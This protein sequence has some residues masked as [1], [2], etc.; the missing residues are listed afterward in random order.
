MFTISLVKNFKSEPLANPANCE[1]LLILVSTS[2]F[3]DAFFRRLKKFSADLPVNPIV[4]SL[5][6]PFFGFLSIRGICYFFIF[7]PVGHRQLI[8]QC[9]IRLKHICLGYFPVVF[10]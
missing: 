8:L 7:Q 5:I 10:L 3:T 6:M 2:F 9:D 4:N 1:T